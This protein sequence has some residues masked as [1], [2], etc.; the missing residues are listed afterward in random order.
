[1]RKIDGK[2]TTYPDFARRIGFAVAN[3]ALEF[4][5]VLTGKLKL[6]PEK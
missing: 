6:G 3:L 1:M 2:E 5:D 4:P